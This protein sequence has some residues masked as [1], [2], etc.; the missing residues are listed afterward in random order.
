[1]D[2][3]ERLKKVKFVCDGEQLVDGGLAVRFSIRRGDQTL[4]GFAIRYKGD[5]FA[6]VNS[7]PHRG[8]S[9]DWQPGEVFD[10]SGLYLIC[11]THGAL[12]EPLSGR[13]VDGPCRGTSLKSIPVRVLDGQ[14]LLEH[15]WLHLSE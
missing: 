8:T 3:A 12:F 10:D 14:V 6:F 2:D 11:A 7:C 13:C 5:V 4:P 9:L 15:D 1:M